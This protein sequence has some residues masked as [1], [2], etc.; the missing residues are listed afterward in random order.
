METSEYI[1]TVERLHAE[2]RARGL[3][4]QTADDAVF[5][6]V[7]LTLRGARYTAFTSCSYLGLERHPSLVA[8]VHDAVDR[9]G[10]QFASSRGYVS[11]P[12]YKELEERLSVIFGGYALAVPT[13]TLGHQIALGVLATEKDALIVDH[14][15]HHSVQMAATLCRANG[16]HVELVR[17]SALP[18]AEGTVARLARK[19]RTVWVACDGVYSMY[20]DLA[21]VGALT[22]L[23]A[24]APNVRVY[25]DDA[26]GMSWAGRHGRGSFLSRMPLSERVVVCT[27]LVKGFGAGG[28]ALAFADPTERER[29]RMCGGPMVFSGPIQPPMLGASVASAR[30]HLSDEIVALQRRL[31]ALVTRCNQRMRALG[32]PLLVENEA[33]IFFVR[34]GLPATAFDVAERMLQRGFYVNVSMYPTVPMKRAGVRLALTT[35]HTMEEVDAVVDALAECV[36]ASLAAAD[37]SRDEVDALFARDAVVIESGKVEGT[38]EAYRDHH[39]G[40]ELAEF[41][42]FTFENYQAQIRLEGPIA[43]AT[44]TYSYRIVTKSDEVV[45]RLG[46]ASSKR[47]R[48]RTLQA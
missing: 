1:A 41:K 4:F 8:G 34:L 21:P 26:H 15:S 24:V 19:H 5:E 37:V 27:S 39:L 47:L 11:C 42:S 10:T 29:V 13:T 28:A 20:G 2:A 46:V 32:L 40:P 3:F 43:V 12:L 23:L 6:G 30:L 33:P 44:E 36:A 35:L 45:D 22:R 7:K 18:D 31:A 17:H 16:A 25:V 14:Q 48:H 38:Y 9:Y